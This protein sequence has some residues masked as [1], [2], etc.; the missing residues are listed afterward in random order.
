[1]NKKIEEIK[2]RWRRFLELRPKSPDEELTKEKMDAWKQIWATC[3]IQAGGDVLNLIAENERLE[4]ENEELHERDAD[5]EGLISDYSEQITKLQRVCDLTEEL[6]KTVSW[7]VDECGMGIPEP[8]QSIC[9][10][11]Q[12]AIKESKK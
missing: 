9:S 12:Q 4:K 2:E 10:K 6:L 5:S 8:L 7:F 1:M 11:T 3:E